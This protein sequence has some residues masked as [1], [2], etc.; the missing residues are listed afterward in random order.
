MCVCHLVHDEELPYP[1]PVSEGDVT[2][3]LDSVRDDL[4][5][6]LGQHSRVGDRCVTRQARVVGERRVVVESRGETTFYIY[7]MLSKHKLITLYTVCNSLNN[8]YALHVPQLLRR[9]Q[10][11]N[12][13]FSS[14]VGRVYY[15]PHHFKVSW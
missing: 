3:L 13:V 11:F 12:V 4:P 2:G 6:L 14:G 15:V 9:V 7:R 1:V 8:S 10:L 5:H